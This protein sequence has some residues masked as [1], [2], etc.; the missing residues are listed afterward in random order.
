VLA[1]GRVWTGAQ[2]K[3][4]GLVDELGGLDRAVALAKAAAKIPEDEDVELV[5]YPARRTL[6]D[7]LSQ[8]LRRVSVLADL[9]SAFANGDIAGLSTL[10]S[11]LGMFRRG[12]ALAL[13]PF[14]VG[15]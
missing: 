15:R 4:R 11:P 7:A 13:M 8:E 10:A 14:A 5:T 1:Q 2:A 12:E 6:Y 9:K 3:E